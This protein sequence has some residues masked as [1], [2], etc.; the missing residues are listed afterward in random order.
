MMSV[1]EGRVLAGAKGLA[2]AVK[3][4][5]PVA[6]VDVSWLSFA[7]QTAPLWPMKVPILRSSVNAVW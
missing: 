4:A 1:S 3:S 5:E 2:H 7:C 6:A